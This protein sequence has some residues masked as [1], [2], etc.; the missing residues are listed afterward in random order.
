VC[1]RTGRKVC[2][3]C[4]APIRHAR[5]RSRRAIRASFCSDVPPSSNRGRREC[6]AP[7][8]PAASRVE[9]N[10]RVSHH[11]HTG[12]PGIP[13]A[14]VLT[15]YFALSPVTGLSCH[16]R[17]RNLFS[18]LDASV[19]ASGP[20]DF[21][22][23][24][25]TLSSVAPPASTASRPTS[26]TIAKRPSWRSGMAIV[27]NMICAK[28]EAEYF[29]KQDWT[30][31]ISLIRHEKLDFRRS[32]NLA[33][34]GEKRAFRRCPAHLWTMLRIAWR[35][36]RARQIIIHAGGDHPD[37]RLPSFRSE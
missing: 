33:A 35:T 28:N 20:H 12:S 8:A 3:H 37:Q 23:R 26:V 21:A 25:V 13:R 10:T 6:R 15:A 18:Q 1:Q 14:M 29:C 24:R 27:V 9:K 34:R 19:G 17:R 2:R 22:V 30:G 16:R 31:Q 4:V 11:G 5:P 7:D 32:D 36:M